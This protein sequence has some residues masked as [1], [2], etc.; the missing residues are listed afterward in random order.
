MLDDGTGLSPKHALASPKRNGMAQL[1]AT[2]QSPGS[3]SPQSPPSNRRQSMEEAP[4]SPAPEDQPEPIRIRHNRR[5]S[6]GTPVDSAEV[7]GDI[8]RGKRE[9]GA[10][11]KCLLT[12]PKAT[13]A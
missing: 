7:L 6:V 5:A 9:E 13:S 11:I 2:P 1:A 3:G 12:T 4:R 8:G 10:K